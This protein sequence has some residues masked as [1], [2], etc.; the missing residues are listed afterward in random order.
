MCTMTSQLSCFT[1]SSAVLSPLFFFFASAISCSRPVVRT[2]LTQRG[3]QFTFLS[4]VTFS[5]PPG[6]DLIG[7]EAI[8]CLSNRSWSGQVPTCK[9]RSCGYP[10]IPQHA[11]IVSVNRTYDGTVQFTCMPGYAITHG[12][13]VQRCGPSR[14]WIGRRP[15]VCQG[16]AETIIMFFGPS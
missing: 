2:F 3:E 8:Q 1:S 5:C 16:K 11:S 10:V 15:V 7:S 4:I 12:D 9:P 14:E 13:K 6:F